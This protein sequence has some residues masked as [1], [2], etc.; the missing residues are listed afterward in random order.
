MWCVCTSLL[1]EGGLRSP[2]GVTRTAAAARSRALAQ[3]HVHAR[4]PDYSNVPA[5]I[6]VTRGVLVRRDAAVVVPPKLVFQSDDHNPTVWEGV[7]VAWPC[8]LEPEV[9]TT[10]GYSLS[11]SFF[12]VPPAH[13]WRSSGDGLRGSTLRHPRR[14]VA[15]CSNLVAQGS[16]PSPYPPLESCSPSIDVRARWARATERSPSRAPLLAHHTVHAAKSIISACAH[17]AVMGISE[18]VVYASIIAHFAIV[19][20]H[21]PPPDPVCGC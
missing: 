18:C 14:A 16:G 2:L 3:A 11:L 4:I 19:C 8:Q 9:D 6:D 5:R 20:L 21:R 10:H 1:T 15:K 7:W 12:P 13:R 17:C